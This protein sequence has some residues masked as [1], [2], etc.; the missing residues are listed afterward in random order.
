[1]QRSDTR[2]NVMRIDLDALDANLATIRA[3]APGMAIVASV[4]ANA[5]GHGIGP[6]ARRLAARGVE[7]LATGSISD[8]HAMRDAGIATP[9]PMMGGAL[10]SAIPEL[11]RHD[12]IPTVH[13]PELAEAVATNATRRMPIYVKVDCGFGRL[14]VPLREG[15][16]FLLDLARHPRIEIAGLYTHLPFSDAAGRDWARERIGRFDDLVAALEKDGLHIPITQARASSALLAGIADRCTAVSPGAL[17]YGLAPLDTGPARLPPLAPVMAEIT[18]RLIQVSPSA[19]DRTPGFEGRYARRVRGATGVVPFG[20]VDGNRMPRAD[21]GAHM[22]VAGAKA[23]IL[24]VSLE[25][26]VLDLSDAPNARVG[27]VVTVLGR[28]ADH[29]IAIEDIARWQGAGVNDVLMS[30]DGRLPQEIT[31]GG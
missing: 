12:L 4:K 16:R 29:A 28:S 25:H 13:G 19:S 23:P 9:I 20:R 10:P 21:S 6:I 1:V 22:L 14:G 30:L 2:A 7:V 31:G 18:S 3:L 26:C 5:Y 15:H 11:L 27:D 24:G 17:L 8:A